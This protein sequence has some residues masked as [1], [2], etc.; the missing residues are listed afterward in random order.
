MT[1][2]NFNFILLSQLLHRY[3]RQHNGD[4]L[5]CNA[6]QYLIKNGQRVSLIVLFLVRDDGRNR[7][8]FF[9]FRTAHN[10]RTAAQSA[11]NMHEGETGLLEGPIPYLTCLF[12]LCRTMPF[13][14]CGPDSEPFRMYT[15]LSWT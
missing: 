10:P 3:L 7:P 12:R 8:P 14:R 6:G 2:R 9:Q 11:L 4:V 13:Q 5:A 15:I 1:T